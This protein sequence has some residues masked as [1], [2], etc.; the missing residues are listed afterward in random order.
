MDSLKTLIDTSKQV[1]SDIDAVIDYSAR[2]S[3]VFNINEKT[4]R[5]FYD[6][7]LV[8]KDLKLNAGQIIVNQ[9]TQILEAIG[10]DSAGMGKIIQSPLMTQ[11]SDK[12]EGSKLTY[13]FQTQQGTVS[14]G[15]SDAEIGYY[16]GDK[17]KKVNPQVYFIQ[18]GLYT[19]STDKVDPEYYF[20]SPKM[21]IIPQDK[22]IAQSVFLYIEGV[23]I[24]WIPFAVFPNRSGRSSGLI[25]PT[26]G[27]D[28][29]YGA[30]FSY[31][32]SYSCFFIL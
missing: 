20:F 26:I 14:M 3:A 30:Y 19:T 18:N 31:S 2:D 24:F 29:K 23:P 10:I 22:V 8:Y 6:G 32:S 27:N 25:M 7:V 15:Y 1:K 9:E 12:Y 16:F 17:I 28:T 4:I 11:G 21:K 5:L 13:S